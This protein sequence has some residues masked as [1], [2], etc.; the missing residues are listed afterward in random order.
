[1]Y[2]VV[3]FRNDLRI[4]DN[5]ALDR[6]LDSKNVILVYIFDKKLI[7]ESTT[8]AFHLNFIRD[9][10][11]SLTQNLKNK[12]NA[13]LNIYCDNTL[14][15]FSHLHKKYKLKNVYSHRIYKEQVSQNIDNE[16]EKYFLS[17]NI[18]W[19]QFNQF[20]IQL[21]HRDR[22]TWSRHWRS[23]TS[24]KIIP[25]KIKTNS[26]F[27]FDYQTDLDEITLLKDNRLTKRQQGGS[28]A[29]E[30]LLTSFLNC[31]SYNFL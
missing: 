24:K 31:I 5:E 8:S 13:T 7:S 19:T 10:L 18:N 2:D 15:V 23:F 14:D 17:H 30:K 12:Y 3:W 6:A 22:N 25:N 11:S 26:S 9:S 20:G 1:M 29:A 16:C 21:N 28:D 27:S 4:N